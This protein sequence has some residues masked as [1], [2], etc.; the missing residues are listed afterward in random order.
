ML[1]G[2]VFV[3]PV[4]YYHC[5]NVFYLIDDANVTTF[6]EDPVVP[7]GDNNGVVTF[8]IKAYPPPT[9][10]LCYNGT[11][12][13]DPARSRVQH[14]ITHNG[15]ETMH[16]VN[17]IIHNMNEYDN[18][19]VTLGVVQ[20]ERGVNISHTVMLFSPCKFILL[21]HDIATYTVREFLA[22][23][24]IAGSICGRGN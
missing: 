3:N 15:D 16:K 20:P 9:I 4:T 2:T 14:L 18:G 11:C 6:P 24:L 21:I 7:N 23:F 10:K 22:E 1:I 5:M 8:E 19:N 12:E 13:L 17:F